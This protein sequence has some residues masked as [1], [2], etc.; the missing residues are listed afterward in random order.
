MTRDG[1]GLR[2]G[3]SLRARLLLAFVAVTVTAVALVTAGALAG[4]S[5]GLSAQEQ[6][7]RDATTSRAAGTAADAYRR[8]GGWDPAQ[9]ADIVS[10]ASGAG[11]RLLVR[12]AAGALVLST[13]GLGRMNGMNGTD[14][15]GQRGGPV[16][17]MGRMGNGGGPGTGNGIPIVRAVAV[18]GATVGSVTL[19]FPAS[20][21]GAGRPVAWRWVWAAAAVALALA[22]AAAWWLTRTLTRPLAVLT[23]T[24]RAFAAGDRDARTH[25]HSPDELGTLAA[26]FD[27]AAARVQVSER[28]R[29]QIAADVAHELRTPLA[30]LQAGLEEL[31]DGLAPPDTAALA[32]LHDQSLRLGRAVTDLA[33]LS[34]ADAARLTLRPEHLDLAQLARAA[35]DAHQAPLRAAGLALVTHLDEPVPAHA[36]P[37]RLHQVIGN[38]LQNCTRH[39]REGDTVTVTAEHTPDGTARLTVTDTGPGI[40]PT[41]LPHVFTRFWR[42]G[43]GGG[44]GLGMA[45]VKSLVEAHG[46]SVQVTSDGRTGTRVTVD[47]P[48]APT[49][50]DSRRPHRTNAHTR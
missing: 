4:T 30:A 38:L 8:V 12:D 41:D 27:E 32:L 45:I 28:A 16:S 7:D 6:A 44:S 43:T 20:T 5:A 1:S 9:L 15:P 49:T 39:C 36:D 24:A 40:P 29:R 18:D 25:L 35:V 3:R 47:L 10:V 13:T 50:A 2:R 26:A 34:S 17:G 48:A 31:R 11:A 22:L 14:G 37:G 19:V 46:G 42:S 33:D 21:S 23:A